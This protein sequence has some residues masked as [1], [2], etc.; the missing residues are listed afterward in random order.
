MCVGHVGPNG[1][2][3]RKKT[4]MINDHGPFCERVGEGHGRFR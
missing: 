4:M 2:A 3:A 1:C